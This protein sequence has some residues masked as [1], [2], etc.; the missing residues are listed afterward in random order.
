MRWDAFD[1][2]ALRER[3][4]THPLVSDPEAWRK[5][6]PFRVAVIEQCL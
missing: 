2:T 4:R 6:R 3:I 5:P 1:E